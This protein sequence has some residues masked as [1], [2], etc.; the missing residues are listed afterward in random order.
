MV[1]VSYKFEKMRIQQLSVLNGA[2][3]VNATQD[4]LTIISMEDMSLFR[5]VELQHSVILFQANRIIYFQQGCIC[6]LE[7]LGAQAAFD[8]YAEQRDA[9]ARELFSRHQEIQNYGNALKL[10]KSVDCGAM[11]ESVNRILQSKL[12]FSK[13][14]IQKVNLQRPENR[15][16]PLKPPRTVVKWL[17][18]LKPTVSH[19]S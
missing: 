7:V 16:L 5:T 14:E 15:E 19:A 12:N 4:Q 9:R 1:A 10:A 2:F 13:V 17:E 6:T 11:R 3:L 8:K 18:G